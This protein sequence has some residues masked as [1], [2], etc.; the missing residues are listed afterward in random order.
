M[1]DRE[2]MDD[3]LRRAAVNQAEQPDELGD[4]CGSCGE[5]VPGDCPKSKR[6]CGHHCNHIWTHDACD[7][8]GHVEAPA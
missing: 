7:W 3:E 4:E 8:C 6:P 1:N 2:R 5:G